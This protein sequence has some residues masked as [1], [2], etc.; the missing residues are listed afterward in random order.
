[1]KAK[2]SKSHIGINTLGNTHIENAVLSV[3]VDQ[4]LIHVGSDE[5]RQ[6]RLDLRRCIDKRQLKVWNLRLLFW[7]AC[8]IP[9]A[10][11]VVS[12][13]GING[14]TALGFL[15]HCAVT[16]G[17]G[18]VSSRACVGA[19]IDEQLGIVRL[20][21]KQLHQIGTILDSR[22]EPDA[23]DSMWKDIYMPRDKR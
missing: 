10:I 6:L 7:F 18:W 5:L 9:Y 11:A 17:M 19:V 3:G 23:H 21:Q 12:G 1:M 15:A 2:F 8:A 14:I 4:S 22:G 13:E 20:E 16:A